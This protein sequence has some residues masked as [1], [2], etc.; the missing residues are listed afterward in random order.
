MPYDV[1]QSDAIVGRWTI[2][3]ATPETISTLTDTN[4]TFEKRG[5]QTTSPAMRRAAGRLDQSTSN[6]I[7]AADPDRTGRQVR[8]V[9][10]DRPRARRRLRGVARRSPG[11]SSTAPA[12]SSAPPK[13][14]SSAIERCGALGPV[15]PQR[16]ERREH[17]ERER[18]LEVDV[19]AAERRRAQQRHERADVPHGAQRELRRREERV[20]RA[21]RRARS[22]RRRRTRSR[23]RAAA[24]PTHAERA[25]ERLPSAARTARSPPSPTG[26]RAS[27]RR[28]AA[29]SPRSRRS[30]G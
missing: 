12:A 16:D 11:T 20:H 26:T 3:A 27:A 14:S 29:A 6:P 7:K 23:R 17:E 15:D 30:T 2:A 22:Q 8:P 10:E 4:A 1:S 18:E 5:T 19:A 21:S 13:A 24:C 25:D 28:A 9:E